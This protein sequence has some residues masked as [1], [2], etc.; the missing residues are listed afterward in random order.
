MK[1]FDLQELAIFVSCPKIRLRYLKEQTIDCLI[2]A[3]EGKKHR[4]FTQ[5]RHLLS[6]MRS[7]HQ[8]EYMI[9]LLKDL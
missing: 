8:N 9:N 3:N 6:M 5:H 7:P 2:V 1:F 4:N